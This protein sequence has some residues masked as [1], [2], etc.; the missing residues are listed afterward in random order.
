MPPNNDEWWKLRKDGNKQPSPH[1][2]PKQYRR[3]QSTTNEPQ[4]P[5]KT[6]TDSSLKPSPVGHILLWGAI[7]YA[8][9]AAIK[10]LTR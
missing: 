8:A 5:E 9:Y 7:F 10:Y 4:T 6:A 3:D 1:Y 2:N